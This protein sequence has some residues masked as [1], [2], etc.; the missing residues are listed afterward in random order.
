MKA[1]YAGS[2]DPLTKGHIYV[3]EQGV[4]LFD[5]LYIAVGVNPSKRGYFGENERID[6]IEHYLRS[7]DLDLRTDV[8]AF[9]NEFLVNV[10]RAHGCNHILR[11]IRNSKDFE[12]ELELQRFNDELAP[13]IK[14]VYVSPP[15]DLVSKSSSMVRGAVGLTGWEDAIKNYTTDYVIQK[16]KQKR[17]AGH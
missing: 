13:D 12:Y 4:K 15:A 2:F 6:M 7:N 1:I 16:L 10:A 17:L 9:E 5:H 8:F 3:I 11:G 14:T